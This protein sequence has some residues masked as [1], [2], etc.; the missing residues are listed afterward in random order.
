MTERL[1]GNWCEPVGESPYGEFLRCP[2]CGQRAVKLKLGAKSP[3]AFCGARTGNPHIGCKAKGVP[4]IKAMTKKSGG[5]WLTPPACREP[6][7][8]AVERMCRSPAYEGLPPR[9]KALVDHLVE[10][11]F[12]GEPNGGIS[13]AGTELMAA[14]G[15]RSRKHLYKAIDAAI[16][17]KIVVRGSRAWSNGQ[18][19]GSSNMWGLVCL[20]RQHPERSPRK[21]STKQD[22]GGTKWGDKVDLGGQRGVQPLDLTR[23]CGI[24]YDPAGQSDERKPHGT[25][26]VGLRG[27]NGAARRSALS[28]TGGGGC[29]TVVMAEP[30]GGAICE[31]N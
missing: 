21:H 7:R 22:R 28:T 10:A 19:S 18:A 20:P 16:G 30:E 15:T 24:V 14:L 9:S 29:G 8:K 12:D 6:P 23:G 27:V 31:R 11:Y 2:M 25:D 3:V 13:G 17:A 5:L 4:L 1:D 26:A